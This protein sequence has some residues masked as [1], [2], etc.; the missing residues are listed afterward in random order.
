MIFNQLKNYRFKSEP[1]IFSLF[2]LLSIILLQETVKMAE[3]NNDFVIGFICQKNVCSNPAFIHMTPGVQIS[4]KSDA[5]GQQYTSPE[6]AVLENKCDVIIVGR[7]I[8]QNDSPV[9]AAIEYKKIAYDAYLKRVNG[10]NFA[11][12]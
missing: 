5:L 7:G 9:E 12:E 3:E 8:I 11:E 1:H 6:T 10:N 2:S 4:K